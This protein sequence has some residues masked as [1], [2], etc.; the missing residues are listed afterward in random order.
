MANQLETQNEPS[1]TSL[2][3]GIIGDA[4]ELMK[5]QLTLF[6]HEMRRD[7]DKAKEGVSKLVTGGVVCLVGGLML[8]IT[9]ALALDALIPAFQGNN[10]WGGFAVVG[11]VILAVGV[12]LLLWARRDIDEVKNPVDETMHALKENV[13]W[14]TKKPT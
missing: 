5:Q 11:V 1:V 6:G 12:G 3:T 2:V 14:T 10:M 9:L 7:V 4:Q 8:A 13:E